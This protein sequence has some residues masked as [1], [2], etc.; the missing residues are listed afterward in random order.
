MKFTVSMKDPDTLQ[1]AI[2]DAVKAD[3]E[4]TPDPDEREALIEIR[5][6]KAAKVAA[7]WFEYGEYLR[8]EIDTEA[9][10]IKVLEAGR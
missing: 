7:K 4:G 6:K 1:D 10:T 2:E 8:V 5:T 3:M 9:G